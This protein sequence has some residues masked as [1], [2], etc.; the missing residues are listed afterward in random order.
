MA[1]PGVVYPQGVWEA[2]RVFGDSGCFLSLARRGDL[3][4]QSSVNCG[5]ELHAEVF[6][7]ADLGP[8]WPGDETGA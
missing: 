3:R 7:S 6:A 8:T 4:K 2:H 1:V 5:A